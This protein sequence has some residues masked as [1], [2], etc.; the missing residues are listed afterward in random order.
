MAEVGLVR[1]AKVALEVSSAVLPL[2][3]KKRSKHIFTQPQLL[4]VLLLMRF[5]EWTLRE[6]EVRLLEHK[7]LREAIGL[8]RAPDYTTLH[9]FMK[10]L[11]KGAIDGAVTETVRRMP[12]PPSGG[13]GG[14]VIAVD[15]TGLESCSFSTYFVTK[16]GRVE[17]RHYLKLVAAVDIRKL[18]VVSLV[19]HEGPSNDTASLP[20]LVEDARKLGP[21]SLVLADAEFDSHQNH[22]YI[23]NK[24]GAM[25]VIPA[26]R[27]KKRGK[28]HGVRAEMRDAFP[29]DLYRQRSLVETVFSMIKRKLSDRAPGRSLATQT[30]QAFILCLAFNIYRLKLWLFTRPHAQPP[31]SAS[32]VHG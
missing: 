17:R 20:Y 5:E 25:S 1:F 26:T 32:Y 28:P 21:I 7:E 11:S 10:R 23:R 27:S 22:D 4:T 12:A 6:T 19:A 29:R 2:Y 9:R 18:M 3:R 13:D 31:V 24:A 15:G 16:T 14:A 30:M 8:S